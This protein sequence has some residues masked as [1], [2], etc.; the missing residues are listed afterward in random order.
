[1]KG[2]VQAA[3]RVRRRLA[4]SLAFGVLI[5]WLWHLGYP[6]PPLDW[7]SAAFWLHLAAEGMVA[8]G[9]S[10]VL[11]ILA[12]ATIRYR[13]TLRGPQSPVDTIKGNQ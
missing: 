12:G 6:E 4:V 8:T 9:I 1:M 7:L 11:F 10:G 5:A 13:R 2:F 3:W